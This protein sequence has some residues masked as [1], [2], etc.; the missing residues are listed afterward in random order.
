VASNCKPHLLKMNPLSPPQCKDHYSATQTSAR[1]TLIQRMVM[2][3]FL[4][5][6][7]D[8]RPPSLSLHKPIH[9]ALHLLT[10]LDQTY[11][12]RPPSLSLHKPMHW[13]LHLLTMLSSWLIPIAIAASW[14]RILQPL[15]QAAQ[16]L[17]QVR[18][19]P[20]LPLKSNQKYYR[21]LQ[22]N[23]LTTHLSEK[24]LLYNGSFSNWQKHL[25]G[26]I[27]TWPPDWS[28]LE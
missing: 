12:T 26:K 11:D 9:W 15:S 6:T 7:Y 10:I 1:C 3:G 25:L 22:Q 5:Q 16:W 20:Q 24:P 19:H 23:I 2:K 14:T 17:D 8:T 27:F 21:S 18:Y 4:D 28:E 13:A